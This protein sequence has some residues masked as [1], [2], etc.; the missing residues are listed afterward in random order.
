MSELRY[1]AYR[2]A[3][4]ALY[5]SGLSRMLRPFTAGTGAILT[6]HQVRPARP[7]A[8]QPN[9]FLEVTPE[10]LDAVLQRLRRQDIDIVSI[11]E[12]H[13]RLT[14]RDFKRPFVAITLDDGYRDNKMCAFPV[15]KK[16]GAPF[17]VFVPTS[18]P[19]RR[20][21]IWWVA[22]EQVIAANDSIVVTIDDEQWPL[23]CSSVAEKQAVYLQV[24]EWLH[25]LP[26]EAAMLETMRDF[27]TRYGVDMPA[28]CASLCMDWDEI[29]ALASDP[30]AT[31]GAHTVNHI[32]LGRADEATVRSELKTSRDVLESKLGREVRHFAYP[33][34]DERA[35]G[36]REFAIAA[37]LG[38]KTAVTTRPGT[39]SP[40]CREYQTALPRLTLNGEFQHERYVDVLL[41]GTATALW[42]TFR[43]VQ[44]VRLLASARS[45]NAPV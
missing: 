12:V 24:R 16:Y 23:A 3:F 17:T 37:E 22:L 1:L 19:E 6:L 39:L 11:D 7:D 15:F 26:S 20:G 4:E 45:A 43:R 21:Q 44:P 42:N 34:G 38:F 25:A 33:Y 5:Y 31:I 29:A 14:E 13:R 27:T 2:G 30:L 36:P 18:F 9:R 35:A 10:F 40:D 32:T 8:F 28:I 41:S